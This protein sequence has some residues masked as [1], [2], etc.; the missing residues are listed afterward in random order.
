MA[1]H[2][3]YNYTSNFQG[4][5]LG[6]AQLRLNIDGESFDYQPSGPDVEIDIDADLVIDG[7]ITFEEFRT[8]YFSKDRPVWLKT[9]GMYQTFVPFLGVNPDGYYEFA[10]ISDDG[11]NV[12]WWHLSQD[13]WTHGTTR[14]EQTTT[15]DVADLPNATDPMSDKAF[16]IATC[17]LPENVGEFTQC[18]LF[19]QI[20][21][22]TNR[23]LAHHD[24]FKFRIGANKYGADSYDRLVECL[25]GLH[26]DG[27]LDS[28]LEKLCL[29]INDGY[30]NLV[31]VQKTGVT[32][33]HLVVTAAITNNIGPS[34]TPWYLT[35]GI[36]DRTDVSSGG[37]Q[38]YFYSDGYLETTQNKYSSQ[39]GSLNT[40]RYPSSAA[41]GSFIP[42]RTYGVSRTYTEGVGDKYAVIA[43]YKDTGNSAVFASH[44]CVQVAT[45]SGD[46]D[47]KQT[48]GTFRIFI[49][50]VGGY[51]RN[52]RGWWESVTTD[53]E[54][55]GTAPKSMHLV[56]DGSNYSL[57][58]EFTDTLNGGATSDVAFITVLQ[59]ATKESDLYG[60]MRITNGGWVIPITSWAES[61]GSTQRVNTSASL[62][63]GTDT[64]YLFANGTSLH[65]I[66]QNGIDVGEDVSAPF[67][68]KVSTPT[69]NYPG[70][71][72]FFGLLLADGKSYLAKITLTGQTTTKTVVVAIDTTTD[73]VRL[74]YVS[75][76]V[77]I[78][79]YTDNDDPDDTN[80]LKFFKSDDDDGHYYLMIKCG[81]VNAYETC[82]ATVELV[83]FDYSQNSSP[84]SAGTSLSTGT[85]PSY[86]QNRTQKFA[87]MA[88]NGP[89]DQSVANA[90]TSTTSA[91]STKAVYDYV[92]SCGTANL[93]STASKYAKLALVQTPSAGSGTYGEYS[94]YF[95]II[96]SNA[97]AGIVGFVGI[98]CVQA[99]VFGS[100]YQSSNARLF[101]LG[102]NPSGFIPKLRVYYVNAT[103]FVVYAEYI[104]TEFSINIK[105]K[106]QASRGGVLVDENVT[107]Y[108][109]VLEASVSYGTETTITKSELA[110]KNHASTG[111]EYGA[112]DTAHYGHTILTDSISN[113]NDKAITPK[114]VYDLDA[115]RRTVFPPI[116]IP[117]TNNG[118]WVHVL[119]IVDNQ[120]H[121]KSYP[122]AVTIFARRYPLIRINV[123]L[124][125]LGITQVVQAT[126]NLNIGTPNLG[127]YVN[128]NVVEVWYKNVAA[129]DRVFVA[130]QVPIVGSAPT[131]SLN[132]ATAANPPTLTAFTQGYTA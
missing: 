86:A 91:P 108:H 101:V 131:I 5:E 50:G 130:S 87:A 59:N 39:F 113:D 106:S 27:G 51:A 118:P 52:I 10:K 81:Y 28:Y 4:Q 75:G 48:C 61:A 36:M 110:V 82:T 9:G 120:D 102:T 76:N 73:D 38:Y 72:G 55:S 18:E 33:S 45:T 41:L 24:T 60:H 115:S 71:Q 129:G 116:Q 6:D 1:Q 127:Y 11:S 21:L 47:G 20:S 70:R 46:T 31:I 40:S 77:G 104:D 34:K 17:K 88:V 65:S 121:Y 83:C 85:W 56:K 94:E 69:F 44:F 105:L 125:H 32:L 14:I 98:L 54:L 122:V 124:D 62:P 78:V 58:I 37:F 23:A 29:S 103:Q 64:E 43:T 74:R 8:E 25:Y 35:N 79:D 111:T 126:S 96:A 92:I 2:Q 68:Y 119:D 84:I 53:S 15:F 93:N 109:N 67:M 107:Y 95:D 66:N 7:T 114:A 63:A 3:Q 100:T 123:R 22:L 112:A 12:M 97:P 16:K 13:G 80:Y 49:S 128:G 132:G 57:V 30:L 90:S 99:R 42:I 26:G 19:L 89:L 117:L